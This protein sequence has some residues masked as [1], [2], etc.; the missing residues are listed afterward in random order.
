MRER[1]YMFDGSAEDY[2]NREKKK[3]GWA[4]IVNKLGVSGKRFQI[5]VN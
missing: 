3:A 5:Y 1:V 4:H 2:H